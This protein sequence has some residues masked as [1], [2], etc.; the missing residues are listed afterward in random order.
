MARS[1]AYALVLAA[2]ACTGEPEAVF[3][4]A[5]AAPPAEPT[6]RETFPELEL[7]R[8]AAERIEITMQRLPCTGCA[9]DD[10][11]LTSDGVVTYTGREHVPFV[12]TRTG[13]LPPVLVDVLAR[14]GRDT[15]YFAAAG[16]Y[17]GAPGDPVIVTDLKI[18]D[19]SNSVQDH[20]QRAPSAVR[21]FEW[22]IS[23]A[24]Q[25]TDWDPPPADD[26]P[27]GARRGSCD[28]ARAELGRGSPP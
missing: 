26:R 7:P 16:E 25:L 19:R 9:V 1:R 28:A 21:A 14:H 15:D 13:R 20:G 4:P 24:V 3:V 23:A 18:G 17:A 2:V 5:V 12:G 10:V 6:P 27:P 22:M 11:R 8:L